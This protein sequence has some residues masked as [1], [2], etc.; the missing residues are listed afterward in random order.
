MTI[1]LQMDDSMLSNE[2][3]FNVVLFKNKQECTIQLKSLT[4]LQPYYIN[5]H[6]EHFD[7]QL[8]DLIYF[9][10]DNHCI[11]ISKTMKQP[12]GIFQRTKN[13]LIHAI[14][15]L[16]LLELYLKLQLL[17]K[18]LIKDVVCYCIHLLNKND[19][20]NYKIF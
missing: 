4:L 11:M 17:N 16:E 18:Y 1:Y 13:K 20:Y 9:K 14:D 5:H 7:Y 6:I 19:Q 10:N 2:E 3:D 8:W 12:F 15:Y